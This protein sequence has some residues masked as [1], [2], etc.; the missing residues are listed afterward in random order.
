MQPRMLGTANPLENIF[1]MH[2]LTSFLSAKQF[3]LSI[4]IL[5][6]FL[7]RYVFDKFFRFIFV[8]FQRGYFL[9]SC[10]IQERCEINVNRYLP[11]FNNL[12]IFHSYY[13]L[14]K[15]KPAWNTAPQKI[16]LQAMCL[17][18]VACIPPSRLYEQYFIFSNEVKLFH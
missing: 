2:T 4:K 14:K 18:R 13:I 17:L 16:Y 5:M 7:Q 15:K 11:S 6:Q 3:L 10:I 1:D 9:F 8:L 12:R